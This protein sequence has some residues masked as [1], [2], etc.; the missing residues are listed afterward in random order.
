MFSKMFSACSFEECNFAI[1]KPRE[2]TA[3]VSVFRDFKVNQSYTCET[4]FGGYQDKN[5]GYHFTQSD[6]RV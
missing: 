5:G 2:S 4:S 1:Q 3:R 6:L